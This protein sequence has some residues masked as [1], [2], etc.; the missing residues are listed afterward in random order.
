LCIIR[1]ENGTRLIEI[2]EIERGWKYFVVRWVFF[3]IGLRTPMDH[4]NPKLKT[5]T[6]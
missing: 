1:E 3:A 4:K 5:H 6:R 2:L